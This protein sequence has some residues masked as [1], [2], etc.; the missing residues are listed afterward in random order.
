MELIIEKNLTNIKSI[1]NKYDVKEAYL[2]GSAATNKFNDK[3]DIDFLFSF[4][5]DLNYETYFNNYFSLLNDLEKLL[6]TQVDLV[7]QKTL[8]NPYLIESI[9]ES[10]IRIL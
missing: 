4:S 3:S 7:S 1:F 2:F 9:N 5:E 10:K 8:K 6:N